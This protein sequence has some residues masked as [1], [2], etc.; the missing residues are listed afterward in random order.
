MIIVCVKAD[1]VDRQAE[2]VY[3][4]MVREYHAQY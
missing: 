2:N 1:D 3:T 4:T